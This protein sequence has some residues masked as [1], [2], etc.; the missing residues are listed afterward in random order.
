[1]EEEKSGQTL[2]EIRDSKRTSKQ[3]FPVPPEL[4]NII[5]YPVYLM[6]DHEKIKDLI[7]RPFPNGSITVCFLNE[8]SITFYDEQLKEIKT[9]SSFVV[10]LHSLENRYFLNITGKLDAIIINLKPGSFQRLFNQASNTVEN[11]IV[12]LIDFVPIEAGKQLKS[13]FEI[14]NI[15]EKLN[16]IMEFLKI[17]L[18]QKIKEKDGFFHKALYLITESKCKI[19]INE[20]SNKLSASKRN[21]ER[22]F[23]VNVG[24]AP[25]EYIR[26]QR[27][28]FVFDYLLKSNFVEWPE[29]IYDFGFYDQSHF[30]H[31]F[32]LVTGLTPSE[33]LNLQ[34]SRM[35]FT[36]RYYMIQNKELFEKGLNAK[37]SGI[38][39]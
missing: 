23:H 38:F 27:M 11:R 34:K 12:D 33:F 31:E 19:T 15:D 25:K 36:N 21:F 13:I 39:L 20:L 29:I 8:K 4:E 5:F 14:K 30:I 32:K 37:N 7:A 26:I 9:D 6:L 3:I 10:G 16:E 2:N 35:I 24:I 1:M 17:L 22:S 18:S 28:N